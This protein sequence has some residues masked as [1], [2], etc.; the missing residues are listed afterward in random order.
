MSELVSQLRLIGEEETTQHEIPLA[1]ILKK[2][3]LLAAY[4]LCIEWS[5]KDDKQF[6]M[7]TGIDPGNWSAMRKG[8]KHFPTNALDKI[9]IEA[10]NTAPLTWQNY[11][12][13]FEPPKKREDAKDKIIADLLAKHAEK[14]MKIS[15]LEQI[16]RVKV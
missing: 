3:T 13:G 6:C 2:P 9:M 8:I 14:D 5:G 10:G 15:I 16:A 12:H 11:L 4:N 1:V 7:A